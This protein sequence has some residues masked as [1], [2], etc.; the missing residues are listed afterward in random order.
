MGALLYYAIRK[1]R[2]ILCETVHIV[3]VL[4]MS[5]IPSFKIKKR[6][7][8]MK[9][10]QWRTGRKKGNKFLDK[11]LLTLVGRTIRAPSPNSNSLKPKFKVMDLS[12]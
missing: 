5:I 8:W 2:V 3:V 9:W 4:F 6:P 11:G 1:V 7:K 12:P 10:M